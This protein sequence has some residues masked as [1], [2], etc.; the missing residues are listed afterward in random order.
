MENR[1]VI[2]YVFLAFCS[3]YGKQFKRLVEKMWTN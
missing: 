3:M 2:P 1:F